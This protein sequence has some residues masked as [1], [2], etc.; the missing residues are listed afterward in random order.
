M[1]SSSRRTR[2]TSAL[3]S[4]AAAIDRA[5]T[6]TGTCCTTSESSL[7]RRKPDPHD[8]DRDCRDAEGLMRVLVALGAT[9]CRNAANP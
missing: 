1:R 5:A 9:P 6:S 8:Q 7:T 4:R 3:T 2:L